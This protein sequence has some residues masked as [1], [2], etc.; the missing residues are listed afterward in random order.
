MSVSILKTESSVAPGRVKLRFGPSG[1]HLFDRATGLNV[2]FDEVTVPASEWHLAPRHVSVALTNGCDLACPFCFVSKGR[3]TLDPRA[4]EAW[5]AELDANGCLGIGFGGGEPTLCKWL[6]DLCHWVSRNTGL[7]VTITTHGHRIDE[8]L[9]DRLAGGVHFVR[10]S[11]DGVNGTYQTLRGKSF[12]DFLK[13]L[14]TIRSVA[15]FGINYLV[16]ARTLPELDDAVR[17]AYDTGAREFLLLP[18]QPVRGTGRIDAETTAALRTWVTNYRGQ[19]PL[20]ISENGATGFPVCDPFSVETGLDSY[21]HIDAFGVLKRSSFDETGVAIDREGVMAAVRALR[22][23][24]EG[25]R[26]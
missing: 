13:R 9:R 11:M 2:L 22:E 16:N 25:E 24:Q 3:E 17:L 10:V 8:D 23:Q 26:R 7:A 15:P 5:L 4:V 14:A 21:A 18:E 19:V 6:P 12:Q 20:S 1:V